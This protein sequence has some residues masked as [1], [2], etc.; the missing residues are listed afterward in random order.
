M[1]TPV[2]NA[3]TSRTGNGQRVGT[4]RGKI[5]S[6]PTALSAIPHH[7]VTSFGPDDPLSSVHEEIRNHDYSQFPIYEGDLGRFAVGRY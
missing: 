6:P 2:S 3:P 4:L 7:T 1:V 5:I